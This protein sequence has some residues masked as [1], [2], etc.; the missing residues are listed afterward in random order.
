[1]RRDSQV[2][3]EE[4]EIGLEE[5]EYQTIAQPFTWTFQLVV[6]ADWSLPIDN[7][8]E[9]KRSEENL[10]SSGGVESIFIFIFIF[11]KI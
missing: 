5:E 1:V 8:I 2:F 11:K 4:G 7:V 9:I 6:K 10:S 3:E